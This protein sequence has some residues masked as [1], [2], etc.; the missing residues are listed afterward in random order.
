MW[1]MLPL[2]ALSLGSVPGLAGAQEMGRLASALGRLLAGVAASL[3]GAG[4]GPI[5][6]VSLP[7]FLHELDE[8][9]ER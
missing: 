1:R 3:T 6:L 8:R 7:R 5:G 2:P 4:S 9:F